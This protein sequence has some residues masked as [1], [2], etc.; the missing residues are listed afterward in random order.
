MTVNHQRCYF[1]ISIGGKSQGRIVFELFHDVVPKTAAN[2]ATLC[3]GTATGKHGVLTY[4]GSTFHRIIKGFMCQGGDF[5][6]GNG[7]GGES[8]Y[9]E[10]FE[11]EDFSMKHDRPGL[12]SM[13]NAGPN[14]NGSQ[15]FIT[16]VPTPH[17]DGKHVVFGKVIKGM[18]TVRAMEAL[19]T[20]ANDVPSSQV[21]IED[22][23][24]LK[25]GE[26]DGVPVPTDGDTLP[27]YVEDCDKKIE[28]HPDEFLEWAKK[29]KEI[30][31][32]NLK[33]GLASKEETHFEWAKK[34]Y[35]K[36]IRYLEAIDPT[37]E[38][39]HQFSAEF[40]QQYFA[41]KVSCLSNLTLSHIQLQDFAAGQKSAER[42]LD[43]A[44]R[45]ETYSTGKNATPLSVSAA[46]KGKAYF[47]LATC[48]Y[49]QNQFDEAL[50]HL[51]AALEC[52]PNDGGIMNLQSEIK[53]VIKV[54]E[55]KEKKMYQKMFS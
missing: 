7:I 37:P 2:F 8:I 34:K 32:T 15:F 12:L 14:T 48:L 30:G 27:D 25:E 39:N 20:G 10:K 21:K 11:D 42:I 53:R 54:K 46:D 38:D 40:K 17:L 9:G 45:L 22:C 23:G 35:S 36:A 41:L 16:T 33:A 49:K 18:D 4:K 28:E 26:D 3:A 31:N 55:A 51:S 50:D 43:I 5:T 6:L 13:A 29:L 47:R 24:T 52:V 19:P 44:S 1:D